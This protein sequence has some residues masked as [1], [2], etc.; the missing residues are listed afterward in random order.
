MRYTHFWR[1]RATAIV[2]DDSLD[3]HPPGETG[4]APRRS[5][6]FSARSGQPL[7]SRQRHHGCRPRGSRQPCDDGG[8]LSVQSQGAIYAVVDGRP[9]AI[10][11]PICAEAGLGLG[12]GAAGTAAP[13][14]RW[15]DGPRVRPRGVPG[16]VGGA[17]AAAAHQPALVLRRPGRASGL[18]GRGGSAPDVPGVVRP[19]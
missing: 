13:V 15:D 1:A 7:K 5:A 2:G 3:G 19:H 14:A 17:G 18:A 4:N 12:A 16:A 10:A 6:R 11:S 9:A 8:A